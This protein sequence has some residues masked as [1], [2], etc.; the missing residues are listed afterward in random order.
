[1]DDDTSPKSDIDVGSSIA[2][3]SPI[4]VLSLPRIPSAKSENRQIGIQTEALEEPSLQTPPAAEPE[5]IPAI[6]ETR[7]TQVRIFSLIINFVGSK[8]LESS[9]YQ[10]NK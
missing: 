2:G 7:E 9:C 10:T 4:T 1:M 6:L 3:G 8:P 5:K